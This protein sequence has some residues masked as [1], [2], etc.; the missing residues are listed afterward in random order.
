MIGWATWS[1]GY[2]D[3]TSIK[4]SYKNNINYCDRN[5]CFDVSTNCAGDLHLKEN[6]NAL[7]FTI[8]HR[9]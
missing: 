5:K 4:Q 7:A 6:I 2:H 3:K 9:S 8:I 1:R